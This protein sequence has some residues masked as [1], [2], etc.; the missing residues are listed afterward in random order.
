MIEITNVLLLWASKIN[1]T[2]EEIEKFDLFLQN[3]NFPQI[4]TKPFIRFS[5][6]SFTAY[7]FLHLFR[8]FAS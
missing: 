7:D 8:T 2:C 3:I 1:F 6:Y 4:I 5:T